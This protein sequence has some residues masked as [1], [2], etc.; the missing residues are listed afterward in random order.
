MNKSRELNTKSHRKIKTHFFSLKKIS[1]DRR[2]YCLFLKWAYIAKVTRWYLQR[3]K[4]FT[5][6]KIMKVIKS[7]KEIWIIQWNYYKMWGFCRS[8]YV[9]HTKYCFIAKDWNKKRTPSIENTY[10]KVYFSFPCEKINWK[11]I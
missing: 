3:W 7:F 1:P 10:T 8:G 11:Q 6:Y 9:F 5:S 2:P 4:W